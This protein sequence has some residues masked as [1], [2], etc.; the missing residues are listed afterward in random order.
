M[1]ARRYSASSGRFLQQDIYY[2]AIDNLGLAQDPLT[3]N[4]YLFTGA[5]PVN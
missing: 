1:G 4:R 5:N 3:A 2:G